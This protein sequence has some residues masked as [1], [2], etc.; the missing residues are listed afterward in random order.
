MNENIY[1]VYDLGEAS[2]TTLGFAGM[3]A[4]VNASFNSISSTIDP[5][6]LTASG[7]FL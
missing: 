4:E 6:G 1:T 3:S 5:K 7:K 2:T